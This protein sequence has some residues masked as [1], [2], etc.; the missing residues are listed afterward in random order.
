MTELADAIDEVAVRIALLGRGPG[1]PARRAGAGRGPTATPTGPTASRTPSTR[2]S[3]LRV[4]ARRFTALAVMS[5]VESG[6]PH[7]DARPPASCS[8]TTSRS[9]TTASPSRTC[10]AIAPA[11]ATSWKKRRPATSPTTSCPSRCTR[12]STPRTSSACSTAYPTKFPPGE[13]LLV[14]QRR[15]RR[16]RAPRRAGERRLVPRPRRPARARAGRPAP[17]PRS[18]GPTSCRAAPRVGYLEEDGLRTNVLHLSVCAPATA[19]R[20]PPSADVHTFWSCAVRGRDRPTGP[21]GRD[22]RAEQRCPR[23]ARCA[24][25]SASGST[26]TATAIRLEGYDAGVSLRTRHDP[27]TGSHLDRHRQLVRRRLAPREAPRP[28]PRVGPATTRVETAYGPIS[29]RCGCNR[30]PRATDGPAGDDGEAGIVV[31]GGS[32]GAA[33]TGVLPP[34]VRASADAGQARPGATG[35]ATSV[36]ASSR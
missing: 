19:T 29:T 24:T 2:S 10:S 33:G 18:S 1:R 20:S 35:Q 9:S 21:R 5:L 31:G 8:A 13:R 15:L 17:T 22:D 3:R 4:A 7:A 12:S 34:G 25:G 27:N 28:S 36:C 14:L 30:G 32:T 6:R 11:S 26:P 16:P 23:G